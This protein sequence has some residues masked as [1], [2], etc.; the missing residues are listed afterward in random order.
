MVHGVMR[1]ITNVIEWSY[2][3]HGS[4]DLVFGWVYLWFSDLDVKDGGW[5]SIRDWMVSLVRVWS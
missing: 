5:V 3:S 1:W 2:G 4:L